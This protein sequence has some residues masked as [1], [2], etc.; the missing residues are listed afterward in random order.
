MILIITLLLVSGLLVTD[1]FHRSINIIFISLSLQLLISG[2]FLDTW[3]FFVCVGLL[4][5]SCKYS[6]FR[7]RNRNVL[8]K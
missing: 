8:R 6:L 3:Q 7:N 1:K 2:T 4:L 5:S